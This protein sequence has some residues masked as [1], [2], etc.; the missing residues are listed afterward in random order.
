MMGES[1]MNKI[2]KDCTNC[3]HEDEPDEYPGDICFDCLR[4]KSID[5]YWEL[6]TID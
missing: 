2:I 3:K 5:K 4:A 6:K 1:N